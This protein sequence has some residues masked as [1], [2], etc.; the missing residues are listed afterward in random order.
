[1]HSPRSPAQSVCPRACADAAVF[2]GLVWSGS[3]HEVAEV[4]LKRCRRGQRGLTPLPTSAP[5]LE[6][7]PG[8]AYAT[9]GLT[10]ATFAPGLGSPAH[11]GTRTGL[12]PATR[13]GSPRPLHRALLRRHGA[14]APL[15]PI[16]LQHAMVRHNIRR[17]RSRPGH[18]E[19]PLAGGRPPTESQ[20][21][22]FISQTRPQRAPGLLRPGGSAA[23]PSPDGRIEAT[24]SGRPP[25][26][27]RTHR[28][29]GR[30]G[31]GCMSTCCGSG[32]SPYSST[33]AR[34]VSL[35]NARAARVCARRC[36]DRRFTFRQ[37]SIRASD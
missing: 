30:R 9:T 11:I 8:M 14:A 7:A 2:A 15:P 10:P 25:A 1:M 23:L 32:L 26:E 34:V 28:G 5:G 27:Q 21:T 12:T 33:Q 24:A 35:S 3:N 31:A 4:E 16:P 37:R 17:R 36:A 29:V 20:T 18:C 19:Y 6:L 22:G 13:P